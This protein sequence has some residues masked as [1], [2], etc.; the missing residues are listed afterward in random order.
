MEY[1]IEH[2]GFSLFVCECIHHQESLDLIMGSVV[3]EECFTL[4]RALKMV[5]GKMRDVYG[6]IFD[7]YFE[8][9][10]KGS[11]VLNS[12]KDFMRFV[13]TRALDICE[14]PTFLNFLLVCLFMSRL[15]RSQH[16]C[17]ML[18]H[19][20]AKC[21]TLIYCLRFV[22]LFENNGGLIGMRKYCESLKPEDL[23][24]IISNKANHDFENRSIYTPEDVSEI[25]LM[26]DDFDYEFEI[27]KIHLDYL[28]NI[29]N[30]VIDVAGR[31]DNLKK[32]ESKPDPSKIEEETE[33]IS[34]VLDDLDIEKTPMAEKVHKKCSYCD[35]K[36]LKYVMFQ[37]SG[38]LIPQYH[39][40]Y[41]NRQKIERQR[42]EE[43]ER[44][45][46]EENERQRKE[47]NERQRKEENERQR[48]E[49]NARENECQ[50]K[51][52][53]ECQRKEEMNARERR[54]MNARERRKM[55]ARERRK[56]NARERME[57]GR[58]PEKGGMPEKG[59]ND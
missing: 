40:E 45:R 53:N 58:L 23:I 51:E 9:E 38:R 6:G 18:V 48:K 59:G 1:D 21:L 3:L 52:E 15:I 36:C 12:K 34:F 54:K 35:E 37:A 46:K 13:V 17:F 27:T 39:A 47:E 33:N 44:Q 32:L 10:L 24:D 4:R 30:S 14:V 26:F 56:M 19:V 42:K 57:E 55:N 43:N 28:Y 2:F 22:K 25:V 50:R 31:Y 7:E 16:E 8:I 5:T 20:L 49:E 29:S 41:E 11:K